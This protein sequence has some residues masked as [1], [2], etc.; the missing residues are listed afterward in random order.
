[1]KTP[2]RVRPPKE[3]GPP[4]PRRRSET[5]KTN[6]TVAKVPAKD[7]AAAM[8]GLPAERASDVAWVVR[9]SPIQ[10]RGVFAARRIRKG[11]RILEYTGERIGHVEAGRRYDDETMERHHTY[12]FAVDA[13]TCIDGGRIGNEARYINHGCDP[14]CEARNI[15]KRIFIHALRA[16]EAGEELFYDYAYELEGPIT[17]ADVKRYA[18]CCGSD[19]CRGTLLAPKLVAEAIAHEEA[20]KKARAERAAARKSAAEPTARLKKPSPSIPTKP[21]KKAATKK[22]SAPAQ[23]TQKP[24]GGR[25]TTP[26][27]AAGKR[28]EAP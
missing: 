4:V 15:R 6:R 23:V 10:G 27:K 25:Q 16:V 24:T 2:P 7:A 13:D 19:I 8:K 14:N 17:M 3:L 26:L 18:C 20:R 22:T 21:V 9:K 11:E 1:M 12:L 5:P 28:R